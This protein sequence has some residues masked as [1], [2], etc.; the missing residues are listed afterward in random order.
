[1]EFKCGISGDLKLLSTS[2]M[3]IPA[4][5]THKL[6]KTIKGAIS[7]VK[8]E[9]E[10]EP[11]FRNEESQHCYPTGSMEWI[12]EKLYKSCA[13]TEVAERAKLTRFGAAHLLFKNGNDIEKA[14]EQ[15]IGI[16]KLDP[17]GVGFCLFC[18]E[19]LKR[20]SP[21]LCECVECACENHCRFYPIVSSEFFNWTSPRPNPH[22]CQNFISELW[23][24]LCSGNCS[25]CKCVKHRRLH[26][27]F[28]VGVCTTVGIIKE[29]LFS[30]MK[31]HG[32]SQENLRALS[33]EVHQSDLEFHKFKQQWKE[34]ELGLRKAHIKTTRRLAS[35]HQKNERVCLQLRE[36]I[37]QNIKMQNTIDA[38]DALIRKLKSTA[39]DDKTTSKEA[40]LEERLRALKL[41]EKELIRTHRDQKTSDRSEIRRQGAIIAQLNAV[42][43]SAH[44]KKNAPKPKPT[45][46]SRPKIS[47]TRKFASLKNESTKQLR[48]EIA[49]L[50][51]QLSDGLNQA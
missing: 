42:L 16:L 51:R 5:P 14:V 40:E 20:M 27:D 9:Q 12:G 17:T 7:A 19:V 39:H 37:V 29:Q 2:E 21:L 18:D 28:R 22:E 41:R 25:G 43:K 26:V 34:I 15:G 50:R 48:R 23:R 44:P 24:S 11:C 3:T 10:Q 4:I 45:V 36:R 30:T 32:D 8:N 1:M 49:R 35:A 31:R 47:L 6:Q 33:K 38:Q 13:V 46:P